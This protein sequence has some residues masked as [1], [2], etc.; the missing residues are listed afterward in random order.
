M[1]MFFVACDPGETITI[2]N[3]APEPIHASVRGGE[4][5]LSSGSACTFTIIRFIRG[6]DVQV[7]TLGEQSAERTFHRE[8]FDGRAVIS[9]RDGNALRLETGKESMLPKIENA[10][11]CEHTPRETKG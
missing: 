10:D 1:A 4:Y 3:Q 6:L 9:S 8:G 5:S 7:T 11:E 2:E